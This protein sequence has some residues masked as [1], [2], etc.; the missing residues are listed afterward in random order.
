MKTITINFK[1][2]SGGGTNGKFLSRTYNRFYFMGY[3]WTPFVVVK[4][5][6]YKK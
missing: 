3:I 1:R 2:W 6:I 5:R 4:W